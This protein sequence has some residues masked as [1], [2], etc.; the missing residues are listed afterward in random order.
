MRVRL[1]SFRDRLTVVAKSEVQAARDGG[2]SSKSVHD[3]YVKKV[4]PGA[5]EVTFDTPW[6]SSAG[7][8]TRR[9]DDFEPA[10]ETGFEANTTPWSSM[11][12]DQL[13]R[14]L[15]QAAAD[16]TLLRTNPDVK[17]IIWFG[18]EELPTSGLGGQLRQ[19]L[20]KSG[21]E[22]WVVKP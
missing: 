6:S 1:F 13:S 14:N 2:A 22:Y 4:R 3:V 15:D 12:S 7:M 16:F 9:F 18:T 21:I 17:R 19:A 10:T 8:G 20:E 5:K 11:T